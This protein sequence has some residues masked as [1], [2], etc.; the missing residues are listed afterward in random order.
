M[1]HGSVLVLATADVSMQVDG[2]LC[3]ARIQ[4]EVVEQTDDTVGTLRYAHR[5]VDKEENH[6]WQR[7]P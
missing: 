6:L 5:L 4:K 7:L 1:K 2:L 3:Q